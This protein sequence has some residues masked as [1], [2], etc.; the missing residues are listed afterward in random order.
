MTPIPMGQA[1]TATVIK[2]V[3]GFILTSPFLCRQASQFSGPKFPYAAVDEPGARPVLRRLA[4]ASALPPTRAFPLA[5][6][7]WLTVAARAGR[8]FLGARWARTTRSPG[9]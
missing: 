2:S 5:P 8:G 4:R 9:S 1:N 7:L 3:D 6:E